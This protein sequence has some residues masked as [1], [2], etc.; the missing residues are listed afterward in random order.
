MAGG[1]FA[2]IERLRCRLGKTA[3]GVRLGIGDDAA[4]LDP[5]GRQLVATMDTLVAGRHFF[6]EV[7]PEDLA[8]KALAVNLSD[9]AAMG[10]EA[11]WCLLSLALPRREEG[12]GE[13]LE[14]FATGWSALADR[15][16]VTLV[17]GDTVAT[18]GP[19]TVSVTALGLSGHGVMR[20]DAA[21]PGDVIWVTGTLGDA[22]A[23][24]DLALLERDQER[25]AVPCSAPQ[26]DALEAR[27]LRP[28]PRLEF[29]AAALAGGVLCAVDCSD[30][31][32]A[33]LGHILKASGVHAQVALDALP[34]SPDLADLARTDPERLRRWPLTGGDDYELI[35]CAAPALSTAMQEA[36]RSLSLRLT[37]VGSILPA[38]PDARAAVTL[39]WR[40]EP[41][42]LPFSWGHVHAL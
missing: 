28:T 6:P 19:L 3:S 41:L 39:T 35:L 29:G 27:R 30:G 23:A 4:W 8:W 14:A 2:F 36:A 25:Q 21:R 16:D 13:W 26:R 5:A 31:F 37:A 38:T 12:Y 9:L 10:A 33:D 32:L 34:L 17:G 24:L 22:A 40:D 42:S 15:H 1:E 11:R 20:R 18:D 7:S